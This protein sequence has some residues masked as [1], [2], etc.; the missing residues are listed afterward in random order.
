MAVYQTYRNDVT[1]YTFPGLTPSA[2]YTVRL[3]FAECYYTGTGWRMF[4]VAINSTS[5]LTNF[6]IYAAAGGHDKAV[7]QQFTATANGSGQIIVAFT[8]GTAGVSQIN[9]IEIITQ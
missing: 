7:V 3:H 8:N 4:N 5:V 2:N 6:D 9:G 1:T